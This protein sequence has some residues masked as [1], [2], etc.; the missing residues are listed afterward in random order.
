MPESVTVR[1]DR[2]HV[3]GQSIHDWSFP[4]SGH[5][6]KTYIPIFVGVTLSEKQNV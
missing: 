6:K 1:G 4:M 2:Q 3:S 5:E